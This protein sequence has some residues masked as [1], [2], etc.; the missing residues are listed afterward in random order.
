[1]LRNVFQCAALRWVGWGLHQHIQHI[2]LAFG[3]LIEPRTA[4]FYNERLL[5]Y[6]FGEAIFCTKEPPPTA[7]QTA[8]GQQTERR[9]PSSRPDG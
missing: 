8:V 7:M 4:L 5:R 3:P 9:Q 6:F 2:Q 1:V